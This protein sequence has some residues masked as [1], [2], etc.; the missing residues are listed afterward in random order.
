MKKCATARQAVHCAEKAA[1]LS[2]HQDPSVLDTLAAAYAQAGRFKEAIATAEHAL[3]L[4]QT[5]ETPA[6]GESLR[7]GLGFYRRGRAYGR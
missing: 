2:K 6:L 5:Q 7:K 3:T 1:E 4:T